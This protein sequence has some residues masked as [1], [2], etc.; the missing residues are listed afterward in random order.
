MTTTTTAAY[1]AEVPGAVAGPVLVPARAPRP[2]RRWPLVF[3]GAPAAVA[4]WSG[5]VGLGGMCGFGIIHPLPGIIDGFQINTAITLPVGI[6]AYGTYALGAWLRPGDI[7]D[8]A[9]TFARRSAVGALLLGMSGQAI[10]HLLA[11]AHAT[12]APWPVVLLVSCLPVISLGFGAALAHLLKAAEPLA[13]V[14]VERAAY[15]GGPVPDPARTGGQ[16]PAPY[17]GEDDA[18]L[19]GAG[20]QD[21][22]EM[23]VDQI[24]E[25]VESGEVWRPDYPALMALTGKRRSWCEKVARD[26]RE[27]V[28]T[29]PPDEAGARTRTGGGS[30]AAPYAEP[31]PYAGE[32]RREELALSGTP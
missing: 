8:A 12:R 2:V 18:P 19:A 6:E 16:Q 25:A 31:G 14:R 3:I 27:L 4:V 32:D 24:R 23:V 17:A 9:R 22:V 7:P 20:R 29:P 15:G 1:E 5:W 26:A 11:A 13:P 10:Y 21:V 30:G 28:L